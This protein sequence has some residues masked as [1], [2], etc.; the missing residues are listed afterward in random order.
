VKTAKGWIRHGRNELETERLKW[1]S[2][3]VVLKPYARV[4]VVFRTHLIP[5]LSRMTSKSEG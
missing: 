3:R 2:E 5:Y 1:R 4:V